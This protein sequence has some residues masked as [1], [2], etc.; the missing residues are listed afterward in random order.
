MKLLPEVLKE[1]FNYKT[2]MVGKWHVGARS[3]ANLPINRGFDTHFGFLKGGED[4]QNQTSSDA[5]ILFVDLW[6]DHQPAYNENGTFSTV[7]YTNEAVSIIN[8]HVKREEE[9]P[10][11]MFLSYQA[12]H[13]PLEAP[14]YWKVKSVK[15]DTKEKARAHMNAL[16][17]ILDEGVKNVTNAL[18]ETGMWENTLLIFQADNGGWIEEPAFGGNNF[19]L[20]GGKVSDYEGGVRTFSFMN[21]GFLPKNLKSTAFSGLLHICDW[22]ETFQNLLPLIDEKD[23][24]KR[25]INYNHTGGNLI[26]NDVPPIDSINQWESLLVPNGIKSN[27]N[28][29]PLSFCN[30]EA[31]C[32]SPGGVFHS[33]GDAALIVGEWKIINGT[34]NKMGIW[35]SFLYPT[36]SSVVPDDVAG[37]VNGCLFNIFDDRSQFILV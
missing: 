11:F 10:L 17:E 14:S 5:G 35:Q 16:V 7:I 9:Q 4:H 33:K 19:P 37:C 20:R 22:Y 28:E 13:C 24:N 15:D 6:R 23:N 31:Q 27:R 1:R 32:D 2:H 8:A 34:Q 18:K 12:T 30:E 3:S 21:G 29:I 36:A 25:N 26:N